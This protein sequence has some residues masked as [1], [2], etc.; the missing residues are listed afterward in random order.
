MIV[1]RF[2]LFSIA[3]VWITLCCRSAWGTP[4]VTAWS[5]RRWWAATTAPSPC[6]CTSRRCSRLQSTW[7]NNL[8]A[9]IARVSWMTSGAVFWLPGQMKSL[10]LS[11]LEFGIQDQRVDYMDLRKNVDRLKLNLRSISEQGLL[12]MGLNWSSLVDVIIAEMPANHENWICDQ[13]FLPHLNIS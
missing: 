7:S 6:C 10:D 3:G 4:F 2:F 12:E 8:R 5:V 13:P 11:R 1:L 9:R